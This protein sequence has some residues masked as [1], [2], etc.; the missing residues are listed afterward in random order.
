MT[1]PHT[2]LPA[3][4][5]L[6]LLLALLAGCTGSKEKA[7]E[8]TYAGLGFT[9]SDATGRDPSAWPDLDGQ[10]LTLLDHGAFAAF[11][12]AAKLFENLTGAKVVHLE[13]DDA[14]SA[15]NRA[16]L[17]KGSP[18]ADVI[19]GIDNVLLLRAESSGILHPYTPQLG[20]RITP[21]F[22]FFADDETRPVG[23]AWPATPVDHGYIAVNYDRNATALRNATI[24]NLNDVREHAGQF[25]TED[26][27]TSSVGLGFLLSTIATYGDPGWQTYWSQLFDGGALVTPGWS[28]AYEQHFSAGYGADPSFGGRAD[29]AIVASYTESPAYEAYYG[30]PASTIAGVVTVPRSTFRQ[31]QT[32]AILNGTHHL[33]AAQAWVEFTLTDAFQELA[34][35]GNAVY[36]V[37][38][39]VDV[40]ST[41]G[42]LDPDP[43]HLEPANLGY[44]ATGA[45]LQAWLTKWTSLCEQHHCR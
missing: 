30:R 4:A 43:A 10:T 22:L 38:P 27:N 8:A 33:A 40:S 36:P 29:R 1:R 21:Q 32:M 12:D 44:R 23:A 5:A 31:V 28:E 7:P 34:A 9:G 39:G 3:F 45:S 16:I 20:P 26:P 13:A 6:V 2:R 42:G 24:A 25:V 19:Y 15:L 14:G 35:P 17:E 11:D 37:V 41:Y 18:S